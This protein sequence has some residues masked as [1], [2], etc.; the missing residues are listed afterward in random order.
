ML[1]IFEPPTKNSGIISGK[2][3]ERSRVCKPGST[4]E[5]PQFYGPEDFYIGATVEV[6][7]R[8]FV[9]VNAD[10]YVLTYMEEHPE[11]FSSNIF[12]PICLLLLSIA[13]LI[14]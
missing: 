14:I 2:F 5:Q 11:L 3:L 1:T 13:L 8:K 7:R 10:L 6:F 9:I 4:P 12:I